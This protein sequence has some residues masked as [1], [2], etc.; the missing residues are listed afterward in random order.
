M[1]I[2]KS[3]EVGLKVGGLLVQ[4]LRMLSYIM[5]PVS[6][7]YPQYIAFVFMLFPLKVTVFTWLG[8]S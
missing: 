8:L 1:H 3:E 6:T 4:L 2:R 5:V 7:L